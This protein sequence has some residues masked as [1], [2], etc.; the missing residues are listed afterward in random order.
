M[1][2]TIEQS[3]VTGT[4]NVSDAGAVADAVCT[5]LGRRYA[6]FAEAPLR[7]CFADIGDAFF[8]RFPGY[9][10]C[11]T[12]YHDLR[13]ALSTVLLM[14]RMVDGYEIGHEAGL[15][16][17]GPEGATLAVL[18]A[19]FHDVGF[20]R[21]D[22]EAGMHGATLVHEHEQRSIDFARAYFARGP[23]ARMAEHVELIHA[24][25]FHQPVAISLAARTAQQLMVGRMLGTV[26]L[27]SQIGG[28]Y[29]LE[30]CRDFLFP[31]FVLAGLDR[32][33]LP[34]GETS[35]LYASAE[36]LLRKTPDFYEHVAQPR[37]ERDFERC[38]RYI[39]PHFG[40]EDPYT[41][42]MQ[43]NLRFLQGVLRD[44]DF[45]RLRRKP[46]PLIPHAGGTG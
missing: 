40:G 12:P 39:A 17:L 22:S 27:V 4:V 41:R 33:T 20:L 3:D 15:P 45:S 19:L 43:R 6:D 31:E 14:A 25:N 1:H 32:Q 30:R 35:V 38:Y 16:S 9:L 10:G 28:R 26:D 2:R 8:G 34:N 5:I 21:R 24:T 42:T 7:R 46:L 18:L 23:Y 13:H 11:D 37:L 36:D 44:N 29:Y